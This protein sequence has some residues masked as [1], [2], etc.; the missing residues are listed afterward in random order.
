[1]NEAIRPMPE[2]AQ[3]TIGLPVLSV[4][5]PTFNERDNV[6]KLFSKLDATLTGIAWE[7]IFVDDNSPDRTWEVVR[8]LARNERYLHAVDPQ[9]RRRN[10]AYPYSSGAFGRRAML[11][12]IFRTCRAGGEKVNRGPTDPMFLGGVGTWV[13]DV[14]RWI[15]DLV[16]DPGWL[17][18]VA[19]DLSA[20][21]TPYGCTALTFERLVRQAIDR[22]CRVLTVS[23]ALDHMRLRENAR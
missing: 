4:V 16:A 9:L 22:G 14:D 5:V 1:M 3:Q 2:N 13:P 20:T 11:A 15:D 17:I 8:D 10:F 18:F 7:V 12:D 21:P 6:A 23:A 19:H